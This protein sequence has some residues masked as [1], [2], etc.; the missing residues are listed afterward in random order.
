MSPDIAKKKR[1]T[2]EEVFYYNQTWNS[3]EIEFVKDTKLFDYL[4]GNFTIKP[5]VIYFNA[6]LVLP[7]DYMA[8]VFKNNFHILKYLCRIF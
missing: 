1:N 8:C 2:N 6:S 7:L 4:I 3:L 5:S